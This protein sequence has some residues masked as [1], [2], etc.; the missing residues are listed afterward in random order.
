MSSENCP[1]KQWFSP[2]NIVFVEKVFDVYLLLGF[3]S[4]FSQIARIF[5]KNCYFCC[6]F[7]KLTKNILFDCFSVRFAPP[8]PPP[9]QSLKKAKLQNDQ[10]SWE[11]KANMDIILI[12][13]SQATGQTWYPTSTYHLSALGLFVAAQAI[14]AQKKHDS[15]EAYF[16][17]GQ[18]LDVYWKW[19]KYFCQWYVFLMHTLLMVKL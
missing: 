18:A 7:E 2:Q 19:S 10:R 13:F 9:P 3:S 6:T 12:I 8:P 11:N 15:Q 4:R 5:W 17:N 16:V 14:E 1:E